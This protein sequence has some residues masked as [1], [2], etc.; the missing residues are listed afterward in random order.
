MIK[1]VPIA[2]ILIALLA[3]T[4]CG[5]KQSQTPEALPDTPTPPTALPEATATT[6]V[7]PLAIIFAP[8]E[9]NPGTLSAIQPVVEQA[10]AQAGLTVQVQQA[11]DPAALPAGL[12]LVVAIPPAANLPDLIAAAPNVQFIAMAVPGLAAAPNLTEITGGGGLAAKAGFLAGYT[13]ALM[14]EDYRVGVIYSN[15]EPAYGQGF[16]DGAIYFCG[17]CQQQYPPFYEYPLYWQISAGA[18]QGEWQVAADQLI[19]SSVTTAYIAPDIPDPALYEYLAQHNVLM[20]GASPP[21]ESVSAH[22]LGTINLDSTSSLAQAIPQVLQNGGQGQI[23]TSLTIQP[24]GS[25]LLGAGYIMNLNDV[26]AQL[27]AGTVYPGAQ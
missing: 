7:T 6:E 15:S 20:I 12:Q 3:L 2:L 25:G 22:W 19:A 27:E 1:R 21:P 18:A 13:A 11:L 16:V 10:A 17:L 26:A 4:A 23:S 14:T 24:G 8:P 9:S 5:G